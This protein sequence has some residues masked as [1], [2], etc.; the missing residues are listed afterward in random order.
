MAPDH[1]ARAI[2]EL[3]GRVDWTMYAQDVQAVEGQAGRPAWNPRLL[4]CIW[5]YAYTQGIGSARKIARR[6]SFDPAFQW[7]AG[8]ERINHHSLADF[9]T[10]TQNVEQIFVNLLGVLSAEGLIALEPVAHDG[11]KVRAC[12]SGKSFRR[13][14]ASIWKRPARM[15]LRWAPPP[16]CRRRRPGSMAR[17]APKPRAGS[18]GSKPPPRP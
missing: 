10:K 14:S 7:L 5:I 12:A 13:A 11:T 2:W 17:A 6:L 1:A 9:R 8:M 15:W 16:P 18:G 4:A 3:S